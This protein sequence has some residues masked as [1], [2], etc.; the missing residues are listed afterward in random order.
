MVN[1]DYFIRLIIYGQIL[2]WMW[3]YNYNGKIVKLLFQEKMKYFF[4][5][6]AFSFCGIVY[7]LNISFE[8][9]NTKLLL[10]YTVFVILTTFIFNEKFN[11]KDS[12]CMAFM[13]VFFNSFYW[14]S[15]LH[16]VAFIHFG[17]TLNAFTQVFRILPGIFLY[18]RWSFN[19]EKK[20]LKLFFKGLLI[21]SIFVTIRG[22]IQFL[23]KWTLYQYRDVW[24]FISHWMNYP[25]RFICLFILI[26]IFYE[27]GVKKNEL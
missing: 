1:L 27:H 24:N 11:F 19:N 13:I 21:S 25:N 5:A 20:V 18:R 15:M 4:Y 2:F 9:F 8:Y 12:I 7:V 16:L 10:T 3:L 23:N 17:I 22:L 14:E 26:K 6:H